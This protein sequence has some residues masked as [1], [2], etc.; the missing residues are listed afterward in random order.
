MAVGWGHI[1][2]KL[3]KIEREVKETRKLMEEVEQTSMLAE[4]PPKPKGSELVAFF[5]D[6][7]KEKYGYSA[8]IGGQSAKALK[9][10]LTDFGMDRS[11]ILVEA[12]LK[13][14]DAY[15]VKKRHD[16]ISL[17]QNLLAVGH[18]ADSG[19]LITNHESREIERTANTM[20]LFEQ[21][22]RGTL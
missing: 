4:E 12:F 1:K 5:C 6:K 7:W 20:S 8:K 16:P 18:F 2:K 10:V 22:D 9:T 11:K 3:E 17:Q 13:M 15:F 14:N 21:V 19:K